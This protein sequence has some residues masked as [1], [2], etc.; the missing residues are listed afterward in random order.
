MNSPVDGRTLRERLYLVLGLLLVPIAVAAAA[1]FVAVDQS[2]RALEVVAELEAQ[3]RAVE[4]AVL[5]VHAADPLADAYAATGDEGVR[6][7][8]VRAVDRAGSRIAALGGLA[9]G[10]ADAP[11]DIARARAAWTAAATSAEA[12]DIDAFRIARTDALEGLDRLQ[13]SL[14]TEAAR[15]VEAA[16]YVDERAR[17]LAIL[18][19]VIGLGLVA[20]GAAYFLRTIA[21]P[22]VSIRD[23]LSE[24]SAGNLVHRVPAAGG[25]LGEIGRHVNALADRLLAVGSTADRS[26]RDARTGLYAAPEFDARLA[27]EL[28]RA[29]RHGRDLTVLLAAIDIERV[30]DRDEQAQLVARVILDTLRPGDVA[31]RVAETR[32]GI[33]LPET[34]GAHGSR[35]AERLRAAVAGERLPSGRHTT[36][37]IGVSALA[38]TTTVPDHL[39]RSASQALDEAARAG[40]DRVVTYGGIP[41]PPPLPPSPG[42]AATG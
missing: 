33:L 23:A 40:G 37:N 8:L 16:L 42:D 38:N 4:L 41:T 12:G 24:I 3:S 2:S 29:R 36:V 21:R 15:E 34:A 22:A 10:V 35:V 6:G 25:E 30:A 20:A 14:S 1:S 26:V 28:A 13:A 9:I 31:A 17:L 39:S 7:Q 11:V 5:D 32:F 27:E 18:L 19:I